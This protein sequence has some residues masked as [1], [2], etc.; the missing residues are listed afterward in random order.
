MKT[1]AR[2][3]SDTVGTLRS[4]LVFGSDCGKD[5]RHVSHSLG[6]FSWC[7]RVASYSCV[8][9]VIVPSCVNI[10]VLLWGNSAL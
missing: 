3:G 8:F 1:A 2:F 9:V 6:V 5:D 7:L 4:V 10:G